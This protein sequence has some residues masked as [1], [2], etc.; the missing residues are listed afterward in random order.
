M[1]SRC[2]EPISW[3][4]FEQYILG[5]L[6]NEK[7]KS[8]DAHL[9]SCASCRDL[10][11]IINREKRELKDIAPLK[12]TARASRRRPLR[13]VPAIGLA[14][15]AMVATIY[16]IASPIM[17]TDAPR[18]A[19]EITAKGSETTIVIIRERDGKTLENPKHYKEGDRLSVL[20]TCPFEQPV[21]WEVAVF[22][23]GE[24]YF[25]IN[26]N[27]LITCGNRVPLPGAF[28]LTGQEPA[29]VCVLVG[30]ELPHRDEISADSRQNL[31]ETS[32]CAV[33]L[34]KKK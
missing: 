4:E 3:L 27:E 32:A 22:Q 16:F 7:R 34:P 18:Q 10:L 31:P 11:E 28:Q 26:G 8:V 29:T 15:A 1:T 20:L 5:E 13:L 9:K 33:L 14:A 6:S 19:F 24:T 17:M 21:Y 30:E 23:G 12:D 2:G 25:P